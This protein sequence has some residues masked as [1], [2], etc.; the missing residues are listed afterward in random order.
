MSSIQVASGYKSQLNQFVGISL[1]IAVRY[2]VLLHS[3][4]QTRSESGDRHSQAG[5]DDPLQNWIK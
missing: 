4:A 5:A 1:K 3:A 2:E